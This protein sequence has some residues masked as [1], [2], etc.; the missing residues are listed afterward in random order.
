MPGPCNT[1]LATHP[2]GIIAEA[3]GACNQT[4][5]FR[6]E[7]ADEGYSTGYYIYAIVQFLVWGYAIYLSFRCMGGF[8]LGDFLMACCCSICYV[9]YRLAV[10]CG[11]RV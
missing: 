3:A 10:P 9:A 5:N 8:N 1:I 7:F 4:A 11:D 2:L 6:E